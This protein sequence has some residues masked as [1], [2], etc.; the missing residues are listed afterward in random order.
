VKTH[1]R[2]SALLEL[3]SGFNPEFTG[4]ENVYFQGAIIGVSKDEMEA[5]IERI[6]AFADIGDFI[7]QPVR[8]YSSGMF[9]RLAFAVIANVD[10][11][12]LVIDEALA[13]G[14][15]F[16]QQKCMRYLRNFQTNGGT[17]LFVSHDTGAI[18]GLCEKAI[19]LSRQANSGV[20]LGNA[21]EIC[22]TYVKQLYLEHAETGGAHTRK[23][24]TVGATKS[25]MT[26]G[27]NNRPSG[28]LTSGHLPANAIQ[29]SDFRPDAESFGSGSIR[30]VD[31]WFE[32]KAKARVQSVIGGAAIHLCIKAKSAANIHWPA[33]GFTIKNY[34]GQNVFA[35]GTDLAFREQALTIDDGDT[36]VINFSFLM[37]I[38]MEGD[39]SITV[40]VAEGIGHDHIQH[41]WLEDAIILHSTKSRLSHG[42]CGVHELSIGI[43]IFPG[44]GGLCL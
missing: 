18:V 37:P 7:D 6:E 25:R 28:Y 22:Q 5:R 27:Q 2:I 8:T 1:G 33:F 9:V 32:D 40:A 31:V 20:T 42:T 10:A 41:H 4:R 15:V 16:F 29:L 23:Q 39:Y 43:E 44:N 19:L 38:L 26:E 21:K 17:I 13:V 24:S 35:E 11:D 36:W 30:I 12:I 3:G 34:L 14:D